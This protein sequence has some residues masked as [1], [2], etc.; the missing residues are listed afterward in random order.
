MLLTSSVRFEIPKSE[1][2]QMPDVSTRI[3]SALRSCRSRGEHQV[4]GTERK[5][6]YSVQNTLGVEVLETA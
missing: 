6:T 5:V 4:R 2:L 3:L 1:I